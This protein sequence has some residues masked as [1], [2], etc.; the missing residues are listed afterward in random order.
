MVDLAS[1]KGML[2]NRPSLVDYMGGGKANIF[3]T[4]ANARTAN[5][6]AVQA[7]E[8]AGGSVSVKLSAEA[9]AILSA[10]N[11]DGSANP[12]L[13]GVQKGAVDFFMSFFDASDIDLSRLSGE[14][15]ELIRGFQDVIADSGASTRDITTDL[16][17]EKHHDGAR[18]AYTLTGPGS[19]LRV[20]ID[21]DDAG[22]PQKLS[23]TDILNGQVEIAD[24]TLENKNGKPETVLLE[25]SAREYAKGSLIDSVTKMPMSLS[26]YG[27]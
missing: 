7:N 8:T 18:R 17:E 19:R 15:L 12:A 20:A 16:L 11:P 10:K 9:Q 3:D 14:T 25:R 21:Y 2:A 6:A 22:K 23:I 4:L 24:V 26:L 5:N 1:L 27:A 13:S